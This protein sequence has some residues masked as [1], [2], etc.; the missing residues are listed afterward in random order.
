[1]LGYLLPDPEHS[2]VAR[3]LLVAGYFAAGLCWLRARRR[4]RAS[5]DVFS[6]WWLLGSVLL[7]LLMAN[8]LFNLRVQAEA[9]VRALAK[10]GNWYDRRQS[11]QFVLAMVVPV[12]LGLGTAIF[13]ATKT[14]KFFRRHPIA[15][16]GWSLLLLYLALRQTQEWKPVLPWLERIRYYDWR[17]ALETLGILL[18]VVAAVREGS[19]APPSSSALNAPETPPAPR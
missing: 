1:M 4:A 3:L 7:F 19:S 9:A 15:L 14:R 6:G 17:L 12:V 11:A 16:A 18:V 13:M 5:A 2:I 8:K 10:A